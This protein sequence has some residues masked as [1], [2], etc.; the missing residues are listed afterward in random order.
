MRKPTQATGVVTEM[1]LLSACITRDV[2]V[3]PSEP[4]EK[5]IHQLLENLKCLTVPASN[6]FYEK[7]V[8]T[9]SEFG[10][11]TAPLT[12]AYKLAQKVTRLEAMK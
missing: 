7:L 2:A 4:S 5:H 1:F 8:V 9:Y 12:A 3:L 11:L 10:L 6:L